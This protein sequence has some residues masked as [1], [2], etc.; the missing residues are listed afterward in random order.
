MKK[1]QIKKEYVD[2]RVHEMQRGEDWGELLFRHKEII[3]LVNANCRKEDYI[4]DIGCFDGKILKALAKEGYQHLYGL[5]F[6]AVS[7]NSFKGTTIQ[8]AR[9]DI[10]EEA[11]P[12][13]EKFDAVVLTD[14][15]EHFFS[16]EE[17]LSNLK[18]KLKPGA[19]IIFSVPNAGWIF[20]GILLSFFP[21]KLFLSTAFGPWGHTYQ[22]TFYQ[23]G[24]IARQLGYKMQYLNGGRMD[25]FIFNEG[26]KKI[27]FELF[28]LILWPLAA[29]FPSLFSDHIF[30]V[31]KLRKK[32]R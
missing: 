19:T 7:Q 25:N 32:A 10:E 24:I 15:L 20:N 14:V 30:G 3:K 23:A 17:I 22:F 9:C 1:G 26:L 8:F 5:D 27:I 2:R 16:P 13:K 29:L 11:I 12:F 21:S 18:N 4:L 6:S 31:Y 28:L